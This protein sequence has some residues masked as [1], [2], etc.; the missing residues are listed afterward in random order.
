MLV[1]ISILSC[2]SVQES[3]T[4]LLQTT[5]GEAEGDPG[6]HQ[7]A[8]H[9]EESH[10]SEGQG[11]RKTAGVSYDGAGAGISPGALH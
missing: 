8:G 9:Q 3:P 4:A 6:D 10:G 7:A 2:R 5:E 1:L 11:G